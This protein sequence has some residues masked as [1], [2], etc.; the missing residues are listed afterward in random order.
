VR[1]ARDR[2]ALLVYVDAFGSTA[3]LPLITDLPEPF[4]PRVAG[5]VQLRAHDLSINPS[6]LI[7]SR[8]LH[9]GS[10]PEYNRPHGVEQ[11][12]ACAI[13]GSDPPARLVATLGSTTPLNAS[14]I[15][16]VERLGALVCEL[17]ER[18][19][20]ERAELERLRRLE[21]IDRLLPALFKVQG[22]FIALN[23]AALPEQLLEA[24]LFGYERGA[25]TGATQ[26]KPGQ[27][28]QA[29]GGT[30]FLDEVGEMSMSAQA[31]F[32]RVLQEREFQRL[33]GTRI[34]RTD[35]RIVAAT[36]LDLQRAIAQGRFREDLFYRL[37][38]FA[39]QL[40]PLRER[41]DDILPLSEAFLGEFS[42]RFG[43]PATGISGDAKRLL[44]AHSW[45]GNVR[46]LRNTL[47]RRRSC[48]TAD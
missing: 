8:L 47:E 40:P 38:V 28:E 15:A 9:V 45:P 10:R 46:E 25:Y 31:K 33:G 35:A 23:C 21:G 34:L 12:Y 37:H 13:A 11:I 36:N 20:S 2:H 32:L 14:E 16:R 43:K 5:R 48:A 39:I 1:E 24:E 18:K 17:C 44:L 19:E 6:G 42:Q 22:P 27:L 29:A 4:R 3:Y 7:E 41:S 26:S 30:L